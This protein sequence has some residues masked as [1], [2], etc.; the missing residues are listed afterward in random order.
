MMDIEGLINE[1]EQSGLHLVT[2]P[3]A[4]PTSS[5]AMTVSGAGGG[6]ASTSSDRA[7]SDNQATFVFPTISPTLIENSDFSDAFLTRKRSSPNVVADEIT[8]TLT[9][10]DGQRPSPP[11]RKKSQPKG[12]TMRMSSVKDYPRKRALQACQ[13]CRTRKT[14]CDNE[15]PTCGSCN[16]MG[17]ECSY[18]DAPASR[19]SLLKI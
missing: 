13:I 9:I 8:T 6:P 7:D 11:G 12:D 15:R 5:N 2:N 10:I 19:S 1:S 14:K 3:F 16:A 17:V 4:L 18:N